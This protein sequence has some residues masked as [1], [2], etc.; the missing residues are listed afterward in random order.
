MNEETQSWENLIIRHSREPKFKSRACHIYNDKPSYSADEAD[1]LCPCGRMIRCHSL[2]GA[3]L[4]SDAADKN[5]PW[6]PP[7]IFI[8]NKTHSVQVPVNIFGTLKPT[9]CKFLRIDS[10]IPVKDIFQLIV[11]DCGGQKPALIMSVYGGAKY[12]TMTERLEKE[13]IRGIIDAAT[14]AGNYKHFFNFPVLSI[15]LLDAWILTAGI[16]NGVSKLVGEGISHYRLLREYPTK[17]KC[18]GMT[19]WGTVNESTRLQLKKLSR[20]N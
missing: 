15:K 3:S 11:D 4:Q 6:S 8:D 1:K 5:I 18:I 2:S 12:F 16:H 10:R 17:L 19:M 7:L 14:M 9:D 20:V 13:F